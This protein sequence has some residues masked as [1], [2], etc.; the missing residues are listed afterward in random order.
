MEIDFKSALEWGK[1]I[2]SNGVLLLLIKMIFKT[3]EKK[4]D[5]VMSDV[6]GVETDS[7]AQLKELINKIDRFK[8]TTDFKFTKVNERISEQNIIIIKEMSSI[9]DMRGMLTRE[10]L[11]IKKN[12]VKTNLNLDMYRKELLIKFDKM[13]LIE[14]SQENINNSISLLK[15]R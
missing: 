7:K 4:V 13:R 3:H 6:K 10:L 1:I 2:G 11:D 5:K 12:N 9:N 8:E 14:R 15:S